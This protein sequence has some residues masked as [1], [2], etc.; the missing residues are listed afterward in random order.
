VKQHFYRGLRTLGITAASRRLRDAGLVLCYH[1]VVEARTGAFG[2]P[3]LH[4]PVES[5]ERQMRWLS[6][7]Y[8]MVSLAELIDRLHRRAPLRGTAAVTFDDGYAGVFANAVPILEE[9]RIP[10]TVFLVARAGDQPAPF[11]WDLPE[12]VERAD[13]SRRESWLVNLHGNGVA[14]LRA[15]GVTFGRSV[16]PSYLPADWATVRA[17]AGRVTLGAHSLTHRSL[18]T[19]TDSDLE[20][21]LG[22]SRNRLHA[23]TGVRPDVFAYPYGRW[24]QRVRDCLRAAG[25]R[26]GVTGDN[27]LN[28]PAADPWSL[29]RINVPAGIS[30]AVFEAWTA[31]LSRRA[32]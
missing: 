30:D 32:A 20:R 1:N 2:D 26:A 29:A 13:P 8:E 19:L 27:R 23:V 5:F 14:I 22:E 7:H 16:P 6:R 3:S 24:D 15:N 10:A 17:A 31:G 12:I 11:W 18:P 9:L 25:Y 28:G 4:L 21:E